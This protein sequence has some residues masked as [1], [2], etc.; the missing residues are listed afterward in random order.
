M[1]LGHLGISRRT[2]MLGAAVFA[3]LVSAGIG[4]DAALDKLT[5]DVSGAFR[6]AAEVSTG[7]I[8]QRQSRLALVIGN[9]RYPDASAPLV[10][11][12]NDARALSTALR[13]D[14]FD[15]DLVEDASRDNLVRA[16]ARLKAKVQSDTVVMLYFGGY[17]VQ[18]AGETFMI[19]VDAAI[20]KE[21]DV[22]RDGISIEWVLDE[23]KERGAR[24]KLVVVDASRRNPY[25]R[26]FR[27]FSRG[28]APINATDN[29][30]ILSSAA[31]DKVIDDPQG[32]RSLLVTE[33]LD[34]MNSS[35]GT[36]EKVFN[37]TRVSVSRATEGQQ[38]PTVSSSLI[39]DVRLGSGP[40]HVTE[41][42]S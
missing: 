3:G 13:N 20:W 4:A 1:N 26:R 11:P 34:S 33:L 39:A 36:A 16:V 32:P 29:S 6:S 14:G 18:S 9:S 2:I 30:L 40:A 24:A 28:L 35:A 23:V 7:S 5:P 25:E 10:Q 37:R 31:P 22:R 21:S 17:G 15:V 38:V 27:S 12:I 8:P 42:G 41:R 19:P